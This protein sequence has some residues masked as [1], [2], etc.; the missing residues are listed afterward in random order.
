MYVG[1]NLS[2]VGG[3]VGGVGHGCNVV[4]VVSFRGWFSYG[5]GVGV[6]VNFNEFRRRCGLRSG[7]ING[8]D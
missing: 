1:R 5:S 2:P 6:I 8:P 4:G 3:A 7:V